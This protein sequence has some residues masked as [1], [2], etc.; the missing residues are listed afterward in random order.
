M[1]SEFT[2]ALPSV[3]K[4][5]I[6]RTTEPVAMMMFFVCSVSFLAVGQRDLDLSLAEDL[7]K[8]VIDRDLVLL[9]Q[10]GHAARRFWRLRQIVFLNAGQS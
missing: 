2:T 8:A 5:A 4:P 7:A 6:G 10:V 1:W 9:H 3:S